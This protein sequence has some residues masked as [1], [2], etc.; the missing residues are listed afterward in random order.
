M[1]ENFLYYIIN[2][3]AVITNSYHGTVFSIIFNKPFISIY[4]RNRKTRVNSLR[5]LIDSEERF[6]RKGE[7]PNYN[8]LI[9]PLNIKYE[10][11]NKEIE[12]SIIFLLTTKNN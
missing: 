2:C 3:D 10:I 11:L 6:L 7:N 8:L 4:Y 9:Q 5:N 1:V 12:N